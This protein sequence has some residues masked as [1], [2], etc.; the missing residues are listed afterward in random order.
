MGNAKVWKCGKK[1][2]PPKKVDNK[3][4]KDKPEVKDG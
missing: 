2:N 1:N 3:K 4:T